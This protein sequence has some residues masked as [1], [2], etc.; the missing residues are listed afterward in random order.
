MKT[1]PKALVYMNK[2]SIQVLT[3]NRPDIHGKVESL[4]VAQ[5]LQQMQVKVHLEGAR[6]FKYCQRDKY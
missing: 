2:Q 3:T 5:D 4:I 1:L 6:H